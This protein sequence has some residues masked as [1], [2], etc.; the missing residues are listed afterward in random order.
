MISSNERPCS[1]IVRICC[2]VST[3]VFA[4]AVVA[5]LLVLAH[6]AAS[7]ADA[8]ATAATSRRSVFGSVLMRVPLSSS[9]LRP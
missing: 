6:A 3:S 7:I 8:S 1:V 2:T 5:G 9:E 4:G